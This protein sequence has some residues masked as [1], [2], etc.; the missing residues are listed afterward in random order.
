MTSPATRMQR[1]KVWAGRVVMFWAVAVLASDLKQNINLHIHW[2]VSALAAGLIF[3]YLIR[4][5]WRTKFS[6]RAPAWV[7]VVAVC[8]PLFYGADVVYSLAEAV[9]LAAMLLGALTIFVSRSNLAHCAFRGFVVAVCLDLLL[10][11]GGFLGFGTAHIMFPGRWGT[12][13][14]YPGS[15]WRVGIS[16]WVFGAYL[17]IKRRSVTSFCL[18]IASTVLVFM[19]GA[20]TG[21]LLLFAGALYLVFVLVEEVGRLRRAVFI[22]A[23]GLGTLAVIVAYSGILS[24]QGG[25]EE[26]GGVGR[27]S[28]LTSSVQTQGLEGLDVADAIR[29]QM[30]SDVVE[31]IREHPLLGTGIGSTKSETIIGPMII[32][33]TYLEVW[34]DLGLLGFV[35]YI[36]L[37]SSWI[38]LV[39]TVLRRVRVL[40]DPAQR[41]LYYNAMFLLVVYGVAGFLHPISTEW[42]EWI[43]FIIPYALVWE[44]ARSKDV[45]PLRRTAV[46]AHA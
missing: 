40:S 8:I 29:F 17:F 46:E 32:H 43:V 4:V 18:L 10:L 15:L 20:R 16:T 42:S 35:T 33:M 23:I 26:Q 36:W 41:A 31:A 12:I 19:D 3:S 34:A 25:T 24:G 30:L 2:V 45:A 37:M 7:L 14:N 38:P 39:P 11:I 44:I 1:Q 5:R 27:V 22:S 9:K 28:Q 6:A 21:I 13:L